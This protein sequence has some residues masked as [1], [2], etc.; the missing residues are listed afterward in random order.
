MLLSQLVC[1]ACA[2]CDLDL[3][4]R[5][6][7]QTER[8][9]RQQDRVTPQIC[10]TLSRRSCPGDVH[11]AREHPAM[12]ADI[13]AGVPHVSVFLTERVPDDPSVSSAQP[14]SGTPEQA[15]TFHKTL[16][17]ASNSSVPSWSLPACLG[18]VTTLSPYPLLPPFTLTPTKAATFLSSVG[19][20][21]I[22]QQAD[23]PRITPI[24]QSASPVETLNP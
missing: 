5:I 4:A 23:R 6:T 18:M 1:P 10:R 14:H 13:Q 21:G 15:P 12:D 2:C 19:A 3:T 7:S 9:S 22:H 16:Y 17:Q 11:T 8:T 24:P 20:R